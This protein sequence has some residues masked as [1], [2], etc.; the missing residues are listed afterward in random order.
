MALYSVLHAIKGTLLCDLFF[1][2]ILFNSEYNNLGKSKIPK[3]NI[4]RQLND[5]DRK[6]FAK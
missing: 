6:R 4:M 5:Y 2:F 3:T 1:I